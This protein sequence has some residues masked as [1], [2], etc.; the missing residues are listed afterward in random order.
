M[1]YTFC[2]EKLSVIAGILSKSQFT[3]IEPV[4][5]TVSL[6]LIIIKLAF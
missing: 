3:V 6:F 1:N 2:P 5:I 4:I